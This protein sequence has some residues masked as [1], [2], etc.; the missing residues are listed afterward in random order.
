MYA[1]LFISPDKY[2]NTNYLGMQCP[3]KYCAKLARGHIRHWSKCRSPPKIHNLNYYTIFAFLFGIKNLNYISSLYLMTN[4]KIG[5]HGVWSES[6][7]RDH[8]Y[9]YI[10]YCILKTI[11]I[12]TAQWVVFF[13]EVQFLHMNDFSML[14]KIY[15]WSHFI[16][17]AYKTQGKCK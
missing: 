9:N 5:N 12:Q 15:F 14:L 10:Q 4:F 6:K 8:H 1:C 2:E 16:F 3:Y 7:E 13:F 11:S 17:L